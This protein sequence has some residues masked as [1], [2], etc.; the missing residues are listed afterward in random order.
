MPRQ[1]NGDGKKNGGGDG[2]DYEAELADMQVL[3][4]HL[5]ERVDLLTRDVL[6]L[7]RSVPS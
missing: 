4:Q 7:F 3:L 2:P 5:E 1:N 6:T